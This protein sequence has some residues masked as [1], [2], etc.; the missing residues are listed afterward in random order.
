MGGRRTRSLPLTLAVLFNTTR[1]TSGNA[2]PR[3]GVTEGVPPNPARSPRLCSAL[4]SAE[5]GSAGFG[6]RFV[7]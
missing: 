3:L 7:R 2:G 1:N 4:D 6:R 5:P